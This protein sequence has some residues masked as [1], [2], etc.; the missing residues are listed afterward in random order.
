MADGG[1][2]AQ[3][4]RYISTGAGHCVCILV[5]LHMKFKS[6]DGS[7]PHDSQNPVSC[8]LGA[9]VKLLNFLRSQCPYYYSPKLFPYVSPSQTMSGICRMSILC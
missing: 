3:E 5:H 1:D 4:A 9:E 7:A 2:G 6:A 8:D